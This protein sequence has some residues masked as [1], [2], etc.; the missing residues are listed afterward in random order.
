MLWTLIPL[1]ICTFYFTH[2][3][4][5]GKLCT[6]LKILLSIKNL[7]VDIAYAFIFICHSQD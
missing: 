1:L 4:G 5:K 7:S 3:M 2:A 6:A